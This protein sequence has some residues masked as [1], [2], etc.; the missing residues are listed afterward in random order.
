M[1]TQ[2][3][4]LIVEDESLIALDL[5]LILTK[6]NYNVCGIADSVQEAKTFVEKYNPELVLLDIQLKGNLDGIDLAKILTAQNIAFVYLSANFQTSILEKAK[7]TQPYGFLIKPFRENEL[8]I[9]LDVAFYRHQN[10]LESK[11]RQEKKIE[12]TIREIMDDS[13]EQNQK[14]VKIISHIQPYIP[15]DY[16]TLYKKHK[17]TNS[18]SYHSFLRI[19]FDEYQQIGESEFLN[20]ARLSSDVF[21]KLKKEVTIES[22]WRFYDDKDFD[23]FI[24]KD[25]LKKLIAKTFELK[26]C[27][28][29]PCLSSAGEIFTMTFYSRKA[30]GY[31]QDHLTLINHVDNILAEAIG[32]TWNPCASVG[33]EDIF[34]VE[35]PLSAPEKA[36]F[37]RRI[38]GNSHQILSVQDLIAIVAPLDTS[39]LILGESGTGKERIAKSIHELSSRSKKPLIIVN[40]ASLPAN[41]IESELFGHE[42]GAFTGAVE[43]RIGKFELADNGTIFL[44]EIGEMPQE[45]QVKLL[46]VLQEQEIER[47]GGKSTIK[48]SVR[49]IAATNRNLEKEV[50]EGRFRLDLY[51]RLYVFP[52]LI[53]P[54]RER[55]DDI[56]ALTDHFIKY[57]SQK[58]GKKI[59]GVSQAVSNQLREYHWPGNVRE[60]EHLIERSMLLNFGTLIDQ[61]VLPKLFTANSGVS[62]FE[63]RLKSDEE[64]S[65]DHIIAVLRKCNGK[66]SG[67]GG[68]A[69]ILAMQPTTLHSKIKKLGISK[70]DI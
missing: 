24:R 16:L 2:R 3:K 50:E 23:L 69:E 19:G 12:K 45:L 60:L 14:L 43:R 1:P 33:A 62:S 32:E 38:I 39:V 63:N 21:D 8:L 27:V 29:L 55:L 51:Y 15:F 48:I 17:Q 10:S 40:C 22:K 28:N 18:R 37:D 7:A 53:P 67:A 44:D 5:K 65:R 36:V 54:L 52:I 59:A 9:T 68:A 70:E 26:S 34:P 20:I 46:R 31:T 35:L 4:V 66:V 47:I 57:Y 56:P 13:M 25:E 6:A 42:K 41:L 61:V 11:L 30:D 64:N 58:N 49:I